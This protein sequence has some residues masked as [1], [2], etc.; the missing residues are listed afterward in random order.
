MNF[1]IYVK[2]EIR[3]I[4]TI[5]NDLLIYINFETRTILIKASKNNI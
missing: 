2:F 5:K 3:T 4:L 1:L